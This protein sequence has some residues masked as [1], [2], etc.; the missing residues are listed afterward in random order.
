M[1]QACDNESI[2]ELVI[3]VAALSIAGKSR[4]NP[5]LAK[6]SCWTSISKYGTNADLEYA[7]TQYGKALNRIQEMVSTG[8]DSI[9]IALIAALLIFVFES[10]HGDTLRE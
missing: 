6:V 7:L 9:R 10:L 8:Q 2:R 4:N 5:K 3:A 1:T